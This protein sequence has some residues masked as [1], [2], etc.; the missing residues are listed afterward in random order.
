VV[1][2]FITLLLIYTIVIIGISQDYQVM[3]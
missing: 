3:Y 1:E 2:N